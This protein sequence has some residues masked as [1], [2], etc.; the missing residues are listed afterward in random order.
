VIGGFA[1][2]EA[3]SMQ[4]AIELTERFLRV[5]GDAWEIE[6]EVRQLTARSSAA[7]RVRILQLR[8]KLPSASWWAEPK[9]CGGGDSARIQRQEA[10]ASR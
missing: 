7:N 10:I 3:P 1:I 9:G 8:V 6:C 4:V 5:H 2:L